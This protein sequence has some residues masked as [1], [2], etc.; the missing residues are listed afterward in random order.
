MRL[1]ADQ[2]LPFE[3]KSQPSHCHDMNDL[4]ALLVQPH[5]LLA[6]FMQL[7]ECL[8]SRVLFFDEPVISESSRSSYLIGPN[9]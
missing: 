8:L 6:S 1:V 5:D 7:L 4:D 9:Q 2:Q 3:L